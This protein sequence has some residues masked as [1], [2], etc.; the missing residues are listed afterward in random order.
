MLTTSISCDIDKVEPYYQLTP[1]NTIRDERS[2]QAVLNG[3]YNLGRQFDLGFFPLHLA[4]YGNEGKITS[5]ISGST[6]FNTNEIKKDNEFLSKLYNSNYKVINLAN[7]LIGELEAG[8][9]VGIS[10]Q[11][12]QEMISEAKYQRAMHY[13][14]LL[15]YFGEY[16]D[17]TSS[18][19]LV[20]RTSFATEIE[21]GS[22]ASVKETYDLI[23]SDLV[24]ASEFGPENIEHVYSG[25]IASKALLAK[26]K[27]YI[28][29]YS[30]SA[31]LAKEV[32]DN[33]EGYVLESNYGDI[34]KN[35]FNSSE[36]L[37]AP[38]AGTGVE[39][40]SKM[41]QVNRTS[42]S[43]FLFDL[44][45][46]QVEGM[47]SLEQEGEYID[48]RFAFA[49]SKDTQGV[50]KQAKYPHSATS[51]SM[52]NTMYHMRLAEVYLIYAEALVRGGIDLDLALE[53]VNIIRARAKV[54]PKQLIDKNTLLEDIRHEKL[55]EIFFENGEPLF[56]LI[57]YASLDG[58][59]VTMEKPTLNSK[60]KYILPI[61]LTVMSSNQQLVQNPGY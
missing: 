1:E 50:N 61:P 19:G 40:G 46:K 14:N 47:A 20:L 29:D 45:D 34:F 44:A 32:V 38:M 26:V 60:H 16:Y 13:F 24:F 30:E 10:D 11:K 57:R 59:D 51:S 58:I 5:N 22:R 56:D 41:E 54:E 27:L 2:A 17:L 23:V 39:G 7:F 21:A 12:K 48:P 15:R 9:A 53:Q 55:L 28:G 25:K 36:V 33:T 37:F 6:G 3:V 52:K 43:E 8:K 42:Y 18:Y 31:E 49:Y 35:M 4:A